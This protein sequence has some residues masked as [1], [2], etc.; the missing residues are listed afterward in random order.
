MEATGCIAD[1]FVLITDG[2]M[3]RVRK[4]IDGQ[5]SAERPLSAIML[6]AT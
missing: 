3:G 2:S 5:V 1:V 6:S 4:L